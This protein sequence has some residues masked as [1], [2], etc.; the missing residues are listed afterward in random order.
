MN[1]FSIGARLTTCFAIM[2]LLTAILMAV[3]LW[4]ID[5]AA[6][7]TNEITGQRFDVER[8]LAA[9][10]SFL[11][12]NQARTRALE[13]VVDPDMVGQLN[14]QMAETSKRID[15][16]QAELR[17]ALQTDTGAVTLL[18]AIEEKR[19]LYNQG[20]A[21]AIEAH[22]SGDF[23]TARRYFDQDMEALVTGYEN[24]VRDLVRYERGLVDSAVSTL[25]ENNRTA[26][27][28]V[29]GIGVLALLLGIVFAV[30]VTR[31]ITIP[32]RRAVDYATAVSKRDLTQ[33]IDVAGQDETAALL[34]ALRQMNNNLL[35]VIGKVQ[36]G[37]DSI[38]TASG[39]IAA[40]NTD[41]AARTEQQ[42]SSLA[43]TA[44]T[45]EELTATVR[46]NADNARTTNNLVSTAAQGAMESG[47]VVAQVV[48]TMARIDE[49]SK[50]VAEII[51]VIDSIAFQTNILALNAAVEAARAGEQGK[52]FAVVASEVRALAQRSAHAAQEIKELIE[53]SVAASTEGNQ[54]AAKAGESMQQTVE[55]IQKVVSII[56]EISSA[57]EEQSAGIEQVNQAVSQMDEVTQQNA[58]LVQEASAASGSMQDQARELS[59]LVATFKVDRALDAAVVEQDEDDGWG[60]SERAFLSA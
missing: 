41:L 23:A 22:L 50:H 46:Q 44:A 25:A 42:A 26:T 7:A 3:S 18:K 12:I 53:T 15:G 34:N 37:S 10:F 17:D 29:V 24:S 33:H 28:I 13:G 2:L 35:A 4:R 56:Q 59:R 58:A 16:L 49:Q 11:Q 40:G 54:L 39:Q 60:R 45:M 5:G 19:K 31:S 9:W 27:Q 47:Q 32:L 48:N 1:R 57:S 21:A 20:T 51:N 14:Q 36:E 43:E 38:A 52:G 55:N 6:R 8:K 30:T